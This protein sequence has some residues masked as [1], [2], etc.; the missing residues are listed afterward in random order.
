MHHRPYRRVLF[1]LKWR[2]V[3]Y[4]GCSWGWMD[5]GTPVDPSAKLLSHGL[6]NSCRFVVDMLNEAGVDAKLV[7]VAEDNDI[8]KEIVAYEPDLVVI[9]AY[10]MRPKKLVDL[11]ERFPGLKIVIRGH[12][13]TPF[14]ADDTI[15][16][17]WAIEYLQLGGT[18]AQNDPRHADEMRFLAED[19]FDMDAEEARHRVPFLPNYYP[20]EH[21]HR[22]A[23]PAGHRHEDAVDVG[24]FGAVR[25]FKNHV[26]QAIASRMFAERIGRRLRFHI[27]G[28]RL[29]RGGQ[30]ASKALD[31]IFEHGDAE[32]IRHD[33]I[34]VHSEFLALVRS[35]DLVTQV[36]FAETFCIVAADAASQDVPL[37]TSPEVPWGSPLFRADPVDVRA[38][39]HKMH[40]AWELRFENRAV[41]P[42]RLSLLDYVRQSR[43]LWLAYLGV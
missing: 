30:A 31:A 6:N 42:N 8:W 23:E 39:A 5:P 28:D 11:A 7:Q 15:G 4:D 38:I 9:E 36:S 1:I 34:P 32:L 40:E 18:V 27:N 29:E 16:F 13:S 41:N 33:W 20:V 43:R 37:V 35:M 14:L 19:L 21:H 25:S 10:W 12:S 2:V 24:C 22:F 17:P 26:G 3:P